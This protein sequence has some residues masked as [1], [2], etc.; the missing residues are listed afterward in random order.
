MEFA[1]CG[2]IDR[3]IILDDGVPNQFPGKDVG[4]LSAAIP[5]RPPTAATP[6]GEAGFHKGQLNS[7]TDF[8]TIFMGAKTP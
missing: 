4:W 3:D 2:R 5:I 1:R 7:G 8:K 6:R